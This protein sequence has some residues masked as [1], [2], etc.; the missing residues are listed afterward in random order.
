M[1]SGTVNLIICKAYGEAYIGEVGGTLSIHVKKHING[2]SEIKHNTPLCTN[3]TK[4]PEGED[5]EVEVIILVQE[6]KTSINEIH[7][8]FRLNRF[9]N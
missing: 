1:S 7:Q 5:F 9:Q 3:R 8:P 4:R 2:K 6:F